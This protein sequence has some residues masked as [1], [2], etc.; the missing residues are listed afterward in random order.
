VANGDS[1]N[2]SG[3]SIDSQTGALTSIPGSPFASGEG[4]ICIA[5]DSTGQSACVANNVGNS[6]STYSI[7]SQTGALKPVK[8]TRT[9]GGT[10]PYFVVLTPKAKSKKDD[11]AYVATISKKSVSKLWFFIFDVFTDTLSHPEEYG[12]GAFPES[13]AV[14]GALLH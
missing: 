6:L 7:D 11:F 4:P 1:N 12:P 2:V 9:K 5:V 3:Y 13:M 8:V 10:S 14:A